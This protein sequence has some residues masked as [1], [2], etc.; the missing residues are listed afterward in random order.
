MNSKNES[1][2]FTIIL[3]RL[4]SVDELKLLLIACLIIIL[5]S[6]MLATTLARLYLIG[7]KQKLS[8]LQEIERAAGKI[9]LR[10]LPKIK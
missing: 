10:K 4:S 5:L 8:K 7:R 3:S 2:V 1:F 9:A 6:L